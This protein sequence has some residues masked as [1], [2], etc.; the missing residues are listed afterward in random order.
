MKAELQRQNVVLKRWEREQ[1]AQQNRPIIGPRQLASMVNLK[2]TPTIVYTYVTDHDR[3][4]DFVPDMV[5]V[6][7]DNSQAISAGGQGCVRYCDFGN[8]IV[9]AEQIVIWDPPRAFGFRIASPNPFGLYHHFG[10]MTFASVTD[11]AQ[12]T[13]SQFYDHADLPSM[14]GYMSSMM[15]GMAEHLLGRFGGQELRLHEITGEELASVSK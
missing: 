13:W 10:L 4:C 14:N 12:L 5:A 3:L 2:A 8:D 11:G 6:N 9:I 1:H 15:N 7:V